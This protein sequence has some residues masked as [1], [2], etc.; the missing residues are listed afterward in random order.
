[1]TMSDTIT[2]KGNDTKFAPHPEGSF[3][4]QCVDVIA[5]GEKVDSGPDYPPKLS[6]KCAL[7]FRTAEKH[8]DTGEHIDISREFT[9]SMGEKA[10]LRKF[11]EQWR[12]KPYSAAAIEEGVPL[13]K[14]T[15]HHGLLS[16]GHKSSA[17]GRTY[18]N[19]VACVAVPKQMA[20]RLPDWTESYTRA[21][22]WKDRKEE[23]AKEARAFRAANAAPPSNVDDEPGWQGEDETDDLPF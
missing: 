2:A 20:D 15:G 18:A 9:V 19:I 21:D 7:V 4:G 23:Y 11:L 1:M 6:T 17:K 5:L 14:L 12:G 3:I 16:I 13:H 10:N 22:F 8:P